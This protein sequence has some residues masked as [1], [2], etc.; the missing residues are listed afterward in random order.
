M[1][2]LNILLGFVEILW[3]ESNIIFIKETIDL[4]KKTP[5]KIL[6]NSNRV[7]PRFISVLKSY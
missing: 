4:L 7:K 1:S 6:N 5:P 2:F 3:I